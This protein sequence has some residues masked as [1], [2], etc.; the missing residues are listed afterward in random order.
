MMA[1][2]QVVFRLCQHGGL[3]KQR[4]TL[5]YPFHKQ[6]LSLSCLEDVYLL[7][8]DGLSKLH[9]LLSI[10]LQVFELGISLL[11]AYFQD[12]LVNEEH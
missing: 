10:N 6:E 11:L 9:R 7:L 3:E 12:E 4:K 8:E 2:T 5:A 1:L